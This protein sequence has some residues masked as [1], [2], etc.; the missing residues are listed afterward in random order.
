M[1]VSALDEGE[2]CEFLLLAED[3]MIP[4]Q[5]NYETG[6]QDI[7]GVLFVVAINMPQTIWHA[8]TVSPSV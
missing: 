6:N 5:Q 4:I 3:A 7:E 8:Y 2:L 1:V